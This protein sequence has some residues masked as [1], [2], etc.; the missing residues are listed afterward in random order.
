MARSFLYLANDIRIFLYL[1]V[2][3]FNVL[4]NNDDVAGF[5]SIISQS[6]SENIKISGCAKSARCWI[7]VFWAIGPCNVSR[8][9]RDTTRGPWPL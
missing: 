5:T 7:T 3:T 8:F 1:Y 6:L 9:L 4:M 2:I